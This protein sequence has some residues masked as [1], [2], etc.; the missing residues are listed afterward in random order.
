MLSGEISEIFSDEE[1]LPINCT[2]PQFTV[3]KSTYL[4]SQ[5]NSILYR[6]ITVIR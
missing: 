5:A 3:Y 1:F 4:Y 2:V 6:F